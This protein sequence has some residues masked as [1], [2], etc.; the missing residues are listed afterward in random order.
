MEGDKAMVKLSERIYGRAS[1]KMSSMKKQVKSL[2]RAGE[3]IDRV[4]AESIWK[5]P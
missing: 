1:L 5:R 3:L 2:A 4:L